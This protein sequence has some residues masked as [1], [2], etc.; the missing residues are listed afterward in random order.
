MKGNL[1]E[2]Q[3]NIMLVILK[4]SYTLSRPCSQSCSLAAISFI[5]CVKTIE[6]KV[7]KQRIRSDLNGVATLVLATPLL[8]VF[9]RV[10]VMPYTM[11]KR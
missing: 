8:H 6:T 10:T 7:Y 3:E 2:N 4:A 11:A 1:C 9:C 5:H